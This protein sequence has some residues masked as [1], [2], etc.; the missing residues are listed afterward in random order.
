MILKA[1]SRTSLTLV[2]LVPD[3]RD[4]FLLLQEHLSGTEF[5]VFEKGEGYD[6]FTYNGP[7]TIQLPLTKGK[8]A[9]NLPLP[10]QKSVIYRIFYIKL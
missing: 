2:L 8:T 3:A 7:L 6:E 5:E 10:F 1:P 4:G 9:Y